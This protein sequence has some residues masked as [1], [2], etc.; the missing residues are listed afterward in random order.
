MF[1]FRRS[2]N[3]FKR[4]CRIRRCNPFRQVATPSIRYLSTGVDAISYSHLINN[5]IL[6]Y[7]VSDCITTLHMLITSTRYSSTV[8]HD[9][10]CRQSPSTH[11]N[12]FTSL[13]NHPMLPRSLFPSMQRKRINYL[14]LFWVERRQPAQR[15][16][17]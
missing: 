11:L 5:Y 12:E 8:F 10:N 15:E 14:L 13:A 17:K 6:I 3:S 4:R 2:G 9:Y 1:A 7:V 16:Y